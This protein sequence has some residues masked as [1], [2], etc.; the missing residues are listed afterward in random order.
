MLDFVEHFLGDDSVRLIALYVEG[1][2]DG[3]RLRALGRQALA[4]GKPIAVWKV[5][6]TGAGSRAAVS[7]TANLTEDYDFYR[8][9]FAEGGFVEVREIYDLIDAAKAFRIRHLPRGRRVAVLTT[10]GGAGVLLADRCEEAGLV[11]PTLTPESITKL[12]PLVPDFAS[13]ANPVDL[14]A[15]Y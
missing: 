4:A 1:L 6:N 14:T 9:A 3:R 5:G 15:G 7:H 10:S 12:Q 11:L 8:D 2:R 13:L